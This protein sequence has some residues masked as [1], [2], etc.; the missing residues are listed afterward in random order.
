MKLLDKA[1]KVSCPECGEGLSANWGREIRKRESLKW[2]EVSHY[3][4]HQCPNCSIKLKFQNQFK[5]ALVLTLSFIPTWFGYNYI[6]ESYGSNWANVLMALFT[7]LIF[8]PLGLFGAN[9]L[10]LKEDV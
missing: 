6:Y 5:F 7:A 2:Y 8:I 10:G 9:K 4:V 3:Y 1:R